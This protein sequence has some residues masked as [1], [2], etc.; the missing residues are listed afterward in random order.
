MCNSRVYGY[1]TGDQ[2]QNFLECGMRNVEC[3]SKNEKL[4]FGDQHI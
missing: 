2:D 4:H 3:G 1:D